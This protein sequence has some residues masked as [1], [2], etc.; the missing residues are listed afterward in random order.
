MV[1]DHEA[2][3]SNPIGS[4]LCGA[5]GTVHVLEPVLKNKWGRSS[6]W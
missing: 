3:G 6:V 1:M 5:T 2:V 4:T